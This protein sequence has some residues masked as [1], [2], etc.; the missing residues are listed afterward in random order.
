MSGHNDCHS[1]GKVR[2]SVRNGSKHVPERP[3]SRECLPQ[4]KNGHRESS[5]RHHPS[6]RSGPEL[7]SLESTHGSTRPYGGA[8]RSWDVSP[9]SDDVFHVPEPFP[10]SPPPPKQYGPR[11][12]RSLIHES[13]W[14]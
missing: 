14:H 6:S 3:S 2:R 1:R 8:S 12:R 13:P 4:G 10:Q 7:K 11:Y 5:H 9:V